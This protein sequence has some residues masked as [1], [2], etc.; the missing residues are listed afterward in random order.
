MLSDIQSYN[1]IYGTT[2]NPYDTTR[3]GRS[4]GRGPAALATGV[5]PLENRFDIGGSLRQPAN[6][7]RRHLAQANLGAL[8]GRGHVPPA[9]DH[10]SERRSCGVSVDAETSTTSNC[11]ERAARHDEQARATS[12][13][14]AWRSGMRN[15]AGHWP[16][17]REGTEPRRCAGGSSALMSSTP[18]PIDGVE[19]MPSTSTS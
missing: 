8:S 1:A 13:A 11:V 17:R 4:S 19:L 14:L 10:Y 16:A 12:R 5:T 6:F 18:S 3:A 9:P 7:L 15:Q 2:N